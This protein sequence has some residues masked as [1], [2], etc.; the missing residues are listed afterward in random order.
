[1]SS[2]TKN[3][4]ALREEITFGAGDGGLPVI[5]VYPEYSEKGDLLNSS[6]GNLKQ[7]VKNL[8]NKVP[9]F[10]N[11]IGEVPTLHVPIKKLY[12]R[13]ALDD[14]DLMVA[15]KGDPGTFYFP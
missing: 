13:K 8:W 11:V 14:T 10:R 15:S 9:A 5:V 1:M 7:S 4:R 6:S 3:S 12:I 2:I